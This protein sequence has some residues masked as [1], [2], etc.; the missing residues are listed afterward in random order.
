MRL[1]FSA[2]QPDKIR[3]GVRRIS[4]MVKNALAEKK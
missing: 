1:N 4:V 2:S 3:E